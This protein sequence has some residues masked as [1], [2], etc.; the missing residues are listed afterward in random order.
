MGG[1][2]SER[3][4]G[5]VPGHRVI[6]S[7]GSLGSTPSPC[8]TVSARAGFTSAAATPA[9]SSVRRSMCISPYFCKASHPFPLGGK[10]YCPLM[11]K[12][13]ALPLLLIAAPAAAQDGPAY[14]PLLE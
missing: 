13:L 12:P 10:G 9:P 7:F 4:P 11:K 14:G 3:P 6:F 5:G 2:R 1:R 8:T